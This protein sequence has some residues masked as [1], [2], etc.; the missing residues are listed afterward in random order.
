MPKKF[1]F[2]TLKATLFWGCIIIRNY[3]KIRLLTSFSC[4]SWD[5]LD[6]V[7]NT[8]G[9]NLKFIIQ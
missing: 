2:V 5:S 7:G 3:Y 1:N 4:L 9:V 8:L 6:G